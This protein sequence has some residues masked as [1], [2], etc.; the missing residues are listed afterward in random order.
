MVKFDSR[1]G[2]F[3]AILSSFDPGIRGILVRLFGLLEVRSFDLARDASVIKICVLQDCFY[4]ILHVRFLKIVDFCS[5]LSL[6]IRERERER[7]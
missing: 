5:F 4:S 6:Q 2:E 3:D 7:E 1:G